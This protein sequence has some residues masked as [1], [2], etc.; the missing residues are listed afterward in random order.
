MFL[1][2]L[3]VILVALAMAFSMAHLAELPGKLRLDKETHLAVQ[4]SPKPWRNLKERSRFSVS[5]TPPQ[6]SLP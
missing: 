1:N 6:T 3:T 5:T 4:Q 2:V